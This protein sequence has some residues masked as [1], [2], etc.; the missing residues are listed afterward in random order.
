MRNINPY[1]QENFEREFVN[2]DLY[3]QLKNDFD[4]IIFN[5][6][7]LEENT[8]TPREQK[9]SYQKTLMTAN[10]FYYLTFLLEKNPTKIYDL[11]CG[12]NIFKRYIPNIIGI[13][14]ENPNGSDFYAD[15][16]DYV[17]DAFVEGH[18]GY[19]ESVFSINALHFIPLSQ[20]QKII[21]D[22]HS[23]I[24]PGG[25]GFLAL[26]LAR[27][28]DRDE[29]FQDLPIEDVEK[30]ARNVLQNLNIDYLVV[31]IDFSVY[32]EYMDGNIRL[33]MQR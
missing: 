3:R 14:A 28:I 4:C 22:F 19:F 11:G 23:M 27:L 17:D 32:D 20:L 5:K 26:N 24:K 15:I 29:L 21:S 9:G 16:H 8:K 7:W 30:Y 1:N 31:D 12:W 13:G 33:V 18:Q 25:R 10:P 6:L 2:T